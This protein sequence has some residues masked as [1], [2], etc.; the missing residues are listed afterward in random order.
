MPIATLILRSALR[1]MSAAIILSS[2]AVLASADDPVLPEEGCGRPY[3]ADVLNQNPQCSLDTGP[4][5]GVG[6][7]F[8]AIG[9]DCHSYVVFSKTD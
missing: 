5:C 6:A 8:I 4:L 1:T 9:G 2:T 7:C 3:C